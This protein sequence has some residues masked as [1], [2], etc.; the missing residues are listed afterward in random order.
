[1]GYYTDEPPKK[2]NKKGGWTLPIVIGL[3]VGALLMLVIYPN[4]AGKNVAIEDENNMNKKEETI[5]QKEEV[6][7]DVSTQ[8]T[9]IVERVSPAVVGVTNIQMRADFWQQGESSD[10]AGTGSGVIY[11]KDKEYAYIVTNH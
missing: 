1:M 5:V 6:H 2:P 9:D 8:I 4:L 11:K 10:E 7:V 3:I